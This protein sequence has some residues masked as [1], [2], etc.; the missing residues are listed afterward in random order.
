TF[1][2]ADIVR[3]VGPAGPITATAVTPVSTTTFRVS[4]PAQN[5]SG[6]YAID[7]G[8]DIRSS[9]GE[10]LDMDLNAGMDILRG[11]SPLSG[12]VLTKPYPTPGGLGTIIDPAPLPGL[13][14]SVQT[15]NLS[16][17]DAFLLQQ[18]ATQRIQIKLNITYPNTPDLVGTLIAPDG[19]RITLFTG[20]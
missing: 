16:I 9:A 10:K 5:V 2:L 1:T 4:F 15:L 14:P 8:S 18:T 13:V 20:V 19:Q 17:A 12:P 6:Q 11:G 7:I 3:F